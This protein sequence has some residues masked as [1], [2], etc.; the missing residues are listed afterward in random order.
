MIRKL[1]LFFVVFSLFVQ[2]A[3]CFPVKGKAVQ[4]DGKTPAAGIV[5]QATHMRESVPGKKDDFILKTKTAADG[6][7][8][9]ELPP[10]NDMYNV[11]LLNNFI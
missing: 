6:T 3:N 11:C 4:A 1:M 2:T 7:F 5:V 10:W 9:L 8:S